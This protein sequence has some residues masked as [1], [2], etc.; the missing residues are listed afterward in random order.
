[1]PHARQTTG[2][3]VPTAVERADCRGT[4]GIHHT[5]EGTH[6]GSANSACDVWSIVWFVCVHSARQDAR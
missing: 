1:V 5:A 2:L 3:R 6:E 4:G